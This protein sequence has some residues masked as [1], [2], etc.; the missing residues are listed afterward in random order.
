MWGQVEDLS[1]L[2]KESIPII[3]EM[4]VG[5]SFTLCLSV[6]PDEQ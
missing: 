1:G 6:T 3:N 5:K 2:K 4:S